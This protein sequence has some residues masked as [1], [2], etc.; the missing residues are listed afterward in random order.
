[1]AVLPSA[2]SLATISGQIASAPVNSDFAALQTAVNQLITALAGGSSATP[3]LSGNGTTVTFVASPAPVAYRKVTQKDVVN[4]ASA[5]DLLNGEITLAAGVLGTTGRAFCVLSGDYLN[6]TGG[7]QTLQLEIK[8]GTTSVWKS[9]ALSLTA[10][11]VRRSWHMIFEIT[12]ASATNAQWLGG[13]FVLSDITAPVT[14]FGAITA[15]AVTAAF[16]SGNGALGIDAT[17]A[18]ALV[19]N[20][21]HGA[22]NAN[23]SMRLNEAVVLVQ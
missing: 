14:G 1:M 8:I 16:T 23:L 10:S 9:N 6:N 21:I 17:A 12:E 20:C 15:G 7:T 22:A 13:S 3:F 2:V 11:A 5:T 18:L 4:I 19:V